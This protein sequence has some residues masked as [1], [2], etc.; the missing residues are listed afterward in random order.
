MT[1]FILLILSGCAKPDLIKTEYVN[2]YPIAQTE[3]RD[4]R[5]G[6]TCGNST[7]SD[8]LECERQLIDCLC[9]NAEKSNLFMKR[10]TDGVSAVIKPTFC[11]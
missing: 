2:V 3:E 7:N 5:C 1:L 11:E 9:A 6:L 8:L 4:L 10:A